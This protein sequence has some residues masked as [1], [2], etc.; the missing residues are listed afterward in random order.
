M[1]NDIL[2][3]IDRL[4]AS[5]DSIMCSTDAQKI[6]AQAE[7]EA[8]D[9]TAFWVAFIAMIAGIFAAIFSYLGY[10]YQKRT[11]LNTDKIS[12]TVQKS[13]FRDI[14]RHLYRNMICTLAMTEKY[15]EKYS[16][17][18]RFC[19]PSEEHLLKLKFLPDDVVHLEKFLNDEE[20]SAQMHHFKLLARNYSTEIDVAISHLKD[21]NLSSNIS[22]RDLDVLSFKPVL[23]TRKVL[24]IEAYVDAT[25]RKY[26]HEDYDYLLLRTILSYLESHI[27]NVS[28]K[29]SDAN[30]N[31][32]R[33]TDYLHD[34]SFK[35]FTMFNQML[36][37]HQTV[38]RSLL[39]D[40]FSSKESDIY[41]EYI[42]GRSHFGKLWDMT[43]AQQ[44][45]QLLQEDEIDIR[46]LLS[47]VISVD[48]FLE[49]PIIS[50]IVS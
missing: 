4:Q 16:S 47:N 50:I 21:R 32:Y 26:A 8:D 29:L 7:L 10:R 15:Q 25:D 39:I 3:R 28:K 48:V 19:Y 20:V 45:W 23:L 34:P 1:E 38:S 18:V 17:G 2:D 33:Y 24:E 6:F 43:S 49:K 11:T 30:V 5:V 37:G 12:M 46:R 27:D 9:L 44:Y 13:L 31:A 35:F 40:F 42:E 22:K 41:L 14:I 36:D